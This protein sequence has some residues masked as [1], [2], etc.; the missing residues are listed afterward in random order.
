[1]GCR[2]M[3]V[4]NIMEHRQ[5]GELVLPEGFAKGNKKRN[6]FKLPGDGTM[7]QSFIMCSVCMGM[8]SVGK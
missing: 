8:T 3:R 4:G 6:A 1:M 5:E 2:D 7:V